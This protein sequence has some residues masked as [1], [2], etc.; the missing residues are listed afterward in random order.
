MAQKSQSGPKSRKFPAKFPAS[1]EFWAGDGFADGC[2][3][4]HA[5]CRECVSAGLGNRPRH[6]K[7]LA[8]RLSNF[9]VSSRERADDFLTSGP[10]VS[11]SEKPFPGT[12]RGDG[13]ASVRDWFALLDT[14]C[15]LAPRRPRPRSA[16]NTRVHYAW[17]G[18]VALFGS[19]GR[20]CALDQLARRWLP[21]ASPPFGLPRWPVAGSM[22]DSGE[23]RRHPKHQE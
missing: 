1:R 15:R 5:F 9:R 20:A 18:C 17:G 6:F 13:F 19:L 10:P 23:Q 21:D 2:Q 7:D 12:R 8:L 16:G 4:H 22:K 14:S 3:H 11:D